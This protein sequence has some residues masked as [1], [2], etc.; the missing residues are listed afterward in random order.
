[1]SIHSNYTSAVIKYLEGGMTGSEKVI[2]E[3]ELA[4]DPLLKA[5]FNHQSEII[6]GLKNFRKAQ[7]KAR[8]DNITVGPGILG[9]LSQSANM[10][11]LTYVVSS[12]LVGTGAYLHFSQDE[13]AR[14]EFDAVNPHLE[15]MLSEQNVMESHKELDFRY[16]GSKQILEWVDPK[17]TQPEIME[18]IMQAE[19]AN[20]VSFAVPEVVE[21]ISGDIDTPS[22]EAIGAASAIKTNYVEAVKIDKVDIEN[23]V[24]SRYRFHYRLDNNKLYLYGKFEAS[25]YEILEINSYQSKR[26]FFF[27]NGHYFRLDKGIKSI[28]PLVQIDDKKVI[29]ELNIIK[30]KNK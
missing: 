30:A 2:F 13:A 3:E 24:S 18:S 21:D 28:A 29:Q 27:Y 5:E 11:T 10:K 4:S 16:L 19:P 20:E 26:L 12:M 15:Y 7:L 22:P 14:M 6:G 23:V 17:V 9:V 8:M 25:P 1:M